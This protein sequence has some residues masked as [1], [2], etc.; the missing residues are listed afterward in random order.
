MECL[1]FVKY[2]AIG[3]GKNCDK[4]PSISLIRNGR[5]CFIDKKPECFSV[6][7]SSFLITCCSGWICLLS[8]VMKASLVYI[9]NRL[10]H[11]RVLQVRN[12]PFAYLWSI[13]CDFALFFLTKKSAQQLYPSWNIQAIS[14]SELEGVRIFLFR[15]NR[16]FQ[17]KQ[18]ESFP[19]SPDSSLVL[20]LLSAWTHSS[21]KAN[22]CFYLG[23]SWF[24]V[25]HN[26]M[27]AL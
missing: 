4:T 16:A 11:S 15:S 24:V 27:K 6:Q 3:K 7:A 26:S 25:S 14:I 13:R 22:L 20:S 19:L 1:C 21:K 23:L 12:F 5:P 8:S 2:Q 9:V 18:K 10:S 17:I